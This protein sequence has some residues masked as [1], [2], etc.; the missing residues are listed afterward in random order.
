VHTPLQWLVL[1]EIREATIVFNPSNF[2]CYPR[3]RGEH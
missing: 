1:L 3:I 2:T